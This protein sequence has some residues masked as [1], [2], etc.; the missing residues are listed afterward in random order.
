MLDFLAHESEIAWLRMSP[1]L[2]RVMC[3]KIFCERVQLVIK[4]KIKLRKPY[5]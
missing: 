5:M 3:D 1:A 4:I 2:V